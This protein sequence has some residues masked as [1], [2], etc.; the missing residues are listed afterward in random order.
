VVRQRYDLAQNKVLVSIGRLSEEKNWFT[1]L[2]AVAQ[3]V[4]RRE[5]IRL[6]LIGDGPQRAA[7][8]EKIQKLGLTRHVILTGLVPFD[9]IP[10]YLK[11]ADLFCFA[12][13][14][15]TQGLVTMEAMAAE[16]PVVAVD[17]TGT[18]DAVENGRQGLLTANDSAALAQA[19]LQLLDDEVLY[20]RLKAAVRDKAASFDMMVQARRAVAVYEQA[21]EAKKANRRIRVDVARAKQRLKQR[22]HPP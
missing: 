17:A 6:I 3:V 21:I 9:D 10:A 8:E 18:R 13:T 22:T 1:L 15:E 4:K 19:I 11:A 14:S 2:E 16:L 20:T 5:D 7:L 12:S